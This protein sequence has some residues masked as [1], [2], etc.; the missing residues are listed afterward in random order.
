[1]SVKNYSRQGLIVAMASITADDLAN[2]LNQAAVELPGGAIV[3]GGFVV[4]ETAFDS[5]DAATLAL[6]DSTTANRY[7]AALDMKTAGKKDLVP[8]GYRVPV[9]SD[10]TFTFTGAL[11]TEGEARLIVEYVVVGRSEFT[12]G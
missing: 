5:A 9:Q 4:V 10:L 6:G 7:A 8:T 12:Q 2:G 3:T 1:M 11:P